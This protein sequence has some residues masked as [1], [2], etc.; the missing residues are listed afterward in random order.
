MEWTRRHIT[1]VLG[2][3]VLGVAA[4]VYL[5]TLTPTV[6]FWDSGE[7]IAVSNI[8]G[9]PHPPGT[10][11]YVMLGR[12]A[13][14]VPIATIAQRVNGLSAVASALAV[15]LTYLTTLRLIR[16]AQGR[17]PSGNTIP[18]DAAGRPLPLDPHGEWL[19]QFGAVIGALMLAFSDNFWENAI[20]AEV[21]SMMSMAQVLVLWLGLK[22][23]ED[24][25]RRPTAGP[26]L[27]AVYVMWLCVGLHLGVG[28][29]G[30]P[31]L[32]LV[33]LVDWR[34]ALVFAMPFLSVLGVV[35]GLEKMTGGVL[36]FSEATFLALWWMQRR[37]NGWILF[38]SIVLA[39]YPGAYYAFG[40]K[41]FGPWSAIITTIGML[42]PLG[43]LAW[44]SREGRIMALAFSLMVIGYSTHIY[45]PI[46]AAQHPA[47]NEGNPSSWSNLRDLLERKQYGSR[48]MLQRGGQDAPPDI[49]RI[50]LDKEFW[51]Y[52]KRQWP[53]AP[54]PRASG[55]M[56][57]PAEPRWWQYLLPLALGLLGAAWQ[58]R[59]RI[60]F[61]TLQALF[62]FSTAGMII[63]L[64]FTS[65]EVRD[66]DYFFTTA[67]HGYAI[68]IG[69]GAAWLVAWVRESFAEPRPRRLAAGAAALLLALQPVLLTKN[70]WFTHNRHGNFVAHDYAYDMLVPLA[71]NSY[72][73]TN[74]DNDT[75][76]LW[77]MQEVENFRRDV[78]VVNLSLLNTDWYILQ[79]R[80]QEPKVPIRLDDATVKVLGL[81]A[82]QDTS[83]HYVYT[84]EYMVHHI[85]AQSRKPGGWTK[86]PYFAV[87]VP[88]HMGLDAHFTL[89][90]LVYRVNRD[91][92]QGPLDEAVTR[93]S[94]YDVFKY[95]GLFLP[96]GTWDPNVYKDENAATLSRNFAAAH[97]QLAYYYRRQGKLDPAIA[98]M[99]R[100]SRMFPDFADVLIP[101]GGFYM[102]RGDTAKALA[103]FEKLALNSPTNPEVRYSYG[104]TLV[105]KGRIE[106][107]LKEFDAAILLDPNY[108]QAYYAAY[109][110]LNQTGQRDRALSYIQ[111][112]VE[113][114]PSD[115]QAQQL[116]ESARGAPRKPAEQPLPPPPQ[117]NLP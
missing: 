3:L 103:L 52:W 27:L 70:L 20:E 43:L 48:P 24:H 65:H 91:T 92:L 93:H 73:F 88:E 25:E 112:W 106:E 72:V 56:A 99:E 78:R 2:L 79:L 59:E 37:L 86:Q 12:L 87:T 49:I 71:P 108:N 63:F 26:L 77:Y 5:L 83:G 75:F 14:L 61:W 95:R 115:T 44:K 42:V 102:D 85:I 47:I 66:R 109:Y 111:R 53:I 33:A 60:S 45:L 17:G 74:G 80:D 6:P 46:R 110:C 89:E 16:L 51:R 98:E 9:V 100:V 22:W 41:D 54:S 113:R 21:Y 94:L 64:N 55:P 117:P 36:L 58:W 18:V 19:A 67:F 116:L 11:F 4:V 96:D 32:V 101:L 57:Q 7:F 29:M 31:L 107:A 1:F 76:P 82:V 105:F 97:L 13:T 40:D 104:L 81:G 38:A 15:L 39:I 8:L 30:F 28:M 35:K 90:A 69:M 68:W 10:P 34:V 50:Q 62:W 23:W 84:N 114:H